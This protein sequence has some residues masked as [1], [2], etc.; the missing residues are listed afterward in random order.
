VVC[1][2]LRGSDCIGSIRNISN[3][4]RRDCAIFIKR[5]NIEDDNE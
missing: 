3:C 4:G 5:K 2:A 1:N